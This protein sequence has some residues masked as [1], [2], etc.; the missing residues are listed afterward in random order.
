MA[1]RGRGSRDEGGGGV[2]RKLALAVGLAT[3]CAAL[4]AFLL[5]AVE[6]ETGMQRVLVAARNIPAGETLQAN[7]TDLRPGGALVH[8][9]ASALADTFPESDF[10]SVQGAVALVDIPAGS[11]LLRS[12]LVA[13]DGSADRQVTLTVASMPSDL[14]AGD[15]VDLLAVASETGGAA[16]EDLCGAAALP[17]CVMPLAQ[18]VV[19]VAANASAHQLT[20]AVP[21][22]E[23]APW[24]LLDATQSIWAV[25]ATGPACPGAEQPISNPATA[26]HAIEYPSLGSSCRDPGSPG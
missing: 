14:V 24:L 5:L 3:F 20:L 4:T 9:G 21:P 13:G 11:V 26:L 8:M 25:P 12:D 23:V 7:T 17:S 6:A 19:I 15:R 18:S 16:A 22:S 1:P 10:R 2:R